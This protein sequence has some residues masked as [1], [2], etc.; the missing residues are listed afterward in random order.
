MPKSAAARIA[1]I[2]LLAFLACGAWAAED[3]FIVLS[4][5]QVW[6]DAA[7]PETFKELSRLYNERGSSHVFSL[8]P[9]YDL[10][11]WDAARMQEWIDEA[12]ELGCFN[13]F[14]IGD[15]IRTADGHLFDENG[16]N[17]KLRDFLFETIAYA[18]KRGLMVAIE[19]VRL[20]P[21]RS[22]E[23]FVRWL[24]SW[25]GDGVPPES[26][27]DIVK[28]SI[29]WF[30]AWGLNPEIS[31][32]VEAFF[33]AAKEVSPDT[34]IYVDSISGIWR[35]PLPFHRW[36]LKRFPG[37]IISHYLNTDQ[38]PAFREMGAR[39]MMVQINPSEEPGP[40]GQFF[41][42]HDRTV[43]K[44]KD[45]VDARVRFVSLAGVDY[46]YNRYN[47]D[48][49]LNVIRPHLAL[50]RSLDEVRAAIAPEAF[51]DAPT[52]D[53]VAAH[54]VGL[55]RE[56]AEEKIKQEP[57]GP[58]NAAGKPAWFG[59]TP[60]GWIIG[61]G[62][63]ADGRSGAK[64]EGAYTEPIRRRPVRATFGLDFGAQRIIRRVTVVPCLAD[65]ETAY[66]ADELRME[67]LTDGEW[68][69][70]PGAEWDEN[71]ERRIAFTLDEPVT[72]E[73]V[74]LVIV[75]QSDDGRGNYRACCQ[76]IGVDGP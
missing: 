50:A 25:L 21:V 57:P 15:D 54:L 17:P 45:V 10:F 42:Y 20:P 63:I 69:T 66:V 55:A 22:R 33:V 41:I 58:L 52:A 9:R 30:G 2:A 56:Q 67:Y 60:D 43:K 11:V 68:R 47:Y 24:R 31:A 72:A 12:K 64:F 44:L 46:G 8:Y 26:R 5:F 29:E 6:A 23:A 73:A 1:T 35:T 27:T 74:R 13:V 49:F 59:E 61:L 32:E 3:R 75:S 37:T 39:N 34:L 48:L 19:P 51:A 53:E 62:K 14:C 16:V 38:V 4:E 28:L 36:L 7:G 70:I 71:T 18:H 76:E 65:G 40:A